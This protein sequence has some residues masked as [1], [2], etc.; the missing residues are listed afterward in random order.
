[1][2][3]KTAAELAENA[4]Q[5][6]TKAIIATPVGRDRPKIKISYRGPSSRFGFAMIAL[7][8]VFTATGARGIMYVRP[9]ALPGKYGME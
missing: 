2:D 5:I 4:M 7:D 9:D 8:V 1:M 6:L 3:M